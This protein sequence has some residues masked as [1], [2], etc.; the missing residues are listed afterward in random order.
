MVDA[1]YSVHRVLRRGGVLVDVRP[2]TARLPRLERDGRVIARLVPTDHTR[3]RTADAAIARLVDEGLFRPVRSG[4]FWFRHTFR[5][6]ASLRGWLEER[7]D[8]AAPA[9]SVPSG[10]VTLRRAVEFTHYVKR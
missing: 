1:L 7:D 5:D 6:R 9:R 4:H 2:S 3:H 8:W 10:R